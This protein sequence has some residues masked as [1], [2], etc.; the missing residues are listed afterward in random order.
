MHESTQLVQT[1]KALF[2]S[3]RLAILATED[4]GQP[5]GNLVAFAETDNLSFETPVFRSYRHLGSDKL[6]PV[7]IR[8]PDDRF[9]KDRRVVLAVQF[10]RAI[11]RVQGW[12]RAKE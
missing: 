7:S 5:Y 11:E 12:Q 6:H 10:Q 1:L 3:Q 9:H 8:G 4:E 2:S